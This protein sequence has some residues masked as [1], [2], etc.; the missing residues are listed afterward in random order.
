MVELAEWKDKPTTGGDYW[1]SCFCDDRYISP[2]IMHVIDYDRE[3]RRLEVVHGS[4]VDTEPIDLF[5][6]EYYPQ[7]KWLY[8]SEP[9]LPQP[10]KS[11]ER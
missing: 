9:P 1:V 3:G 6:K 2:R 7:S 5:L 11:G 8:I 4:L 10:E